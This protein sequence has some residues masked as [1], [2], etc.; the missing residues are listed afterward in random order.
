MNE[1]DLRKELSNKTV[2]VLV[3]IIIRLLKQTEKLEN[4]LELL[5]AYDNENGA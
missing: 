4:E 1:L 2:D 5:N 3:D